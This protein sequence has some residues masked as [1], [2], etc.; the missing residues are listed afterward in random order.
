MISKLQFVLLIAGL[1]M[2]VTKADDVD[3]SQRPKFVDPKT[4]CPMPEFFTDE[5]KEACKEEYSATFRP[6]MAMPTASEQ[7]GERR[8]RR[9]HHH[10]HH[11]H[12]HHPCFVSCALREAGIIV[13][14]EFNPEKLT[15]Y[16]EVVFKDN[17]EL[18]VLTSQAFANCSARAEEFKE[19]RGPM[20]RPSPPPGELSC[21]HRPAFL[22]GCAYRN[23]FKNC[24]ASIWTDTQECNEAREHFRKCKP[25]FRR[26]GSNESFK[27][28]EKATA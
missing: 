15:S 1:C 26:P 27:S 9:P 24:P 8:Q 17:K 16:V 10:H 2:S 18:Q 23:M 14:D 12:H 4:C 5:L 25:K 21:S 11:H 20:A 7:E 13:N 28:A 6:P 3:C 19:M 22:M